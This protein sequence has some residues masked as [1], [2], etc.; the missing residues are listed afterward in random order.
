MIK[1]DVQI[2]FWNVGQG[3]ASSIILPDNK[4]ILIDVGPINSTLSRWL[5]STPGQHKVVPNISLL[6]NLTL[7]FIGKQEFLPK[8]FTPSLY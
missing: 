7:P 8:T 2:D 5:N 3:D 1:R 6:F 4:L